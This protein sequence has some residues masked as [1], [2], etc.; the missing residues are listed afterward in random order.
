METNNAF[1]IPDAFFGNQ[2]KR[3]ISFFSHD[4]NVTQSTK[5]RGRAFTYICK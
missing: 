1:V 5:A 3:K 2:E 4:D